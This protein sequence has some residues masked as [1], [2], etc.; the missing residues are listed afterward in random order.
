[1]TRH[2]WSPEA[3]VAAIPDRPGVY[4]FRDAA[5]KVLYV[6]KARGLRARVSSY[7]RPGGDGRAGIRFLE[8]DAHDADRAHRYYGRRFAP[9][10]QSQGITLRGQLEDDRVGIGPD[11]GVR[12]ARFTI[13]DD[14]AARPVRW[15]VVH[16]RSMSGRCASSQL[17]NVS[18]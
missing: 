3:D 1:M 11:G 18:M 16:Q 8:R 12:R 7:R 14:L 2:D 10:R 13:P 9:V 5:D 4:I 15:R 17:A 6:G